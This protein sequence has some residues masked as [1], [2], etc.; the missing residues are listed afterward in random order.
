MTQIKQL[1]PVDS[2][3]KRPQKYFLGLFPISD[4]IED[5]VHN[6]RRSVDIWGWKVRWPFPIAYALNS[7]TAMVFGTSV[8]GA[9][10]KASWFIRA[11]HRLFRR[12]SDARYWLYYRFHPKHRY[13]MVNTG[14]GYGY[15]ERDSQLLGAM[16]A[17]FL[18]YMEDCEGIHDPGVEAQEILHWWRIKRPTD[19]ARARALLDALYALNRSPPEWKEVTLGSGEILYEMV[20]APPSEEYLAQHKELTELEKSIEDEAQEYLHRIVT[21]RPSMWT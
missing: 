11:S 18:G 7:S 5:L 15:H 13:H 10:P 14:L 20:S 9:R 19:E 3:E 4:F 17:V 2:E 16:V 6:K 12:L 8:Y 21:L 1:L